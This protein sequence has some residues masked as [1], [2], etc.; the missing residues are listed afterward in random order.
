MNIAIVDADLIGGRKHRHPNLACMKISGYYKKLENNV[1]LKTDY[2]NLNNFDKVYISKVFTDTIIDNKILN[3]EN[4]EYGGTGFY[5]DKAE[6]LPYKIEHHMPDYNL[7]DNWIKSEINRGIKS[8]Y[9]YDYND[10][11]I[12]W[13][14]RGCIW[15]CKFCVNYNA[16]EVYEHSH[17]K[18]FLNISRKYI[19]LWDDNFLAFPQWKKILYDLKLT[20]KPFQFR[21]GLDMRIMTE[22]KAYEFSKVKYIGDYIFAFDNI[23]YKDV[24]INNIKLWK[25]Y[26]TK[27]TKLYVLCGFDENNIY[28]ELFYKQDIINTFERIIILMKYKCLPYIMRHEN[29]VNSKHR[30]MYINLA[31]WCNQPS[32]FKKLSFNEFVE[33]DG[34]GK[35]YNYSSK[36]YLNEFK[37]VYP[38]IAKEY[39]D[40]KFEINSG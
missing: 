2:N 12:G 15:K 5:F 16:S 11:S 18:E 14:T 40:L 32:L 19:Y 37:Q 22:D 27:Q 38:E 28:D 3:N 29:Y 31:R 25:K 7:Y 24:I 1:I 39:F 30:G 10:Y 4:I 33:L 8:S 26:I 36:K 35:S 17:V 9:F 20:N 13:T 23:S 34:K 21:Q 6:S